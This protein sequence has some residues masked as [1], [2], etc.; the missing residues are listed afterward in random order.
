VS[1]TSRFPLGYND[2]GLKDPG[3]NQLG[4]GGDVNVPNVGEVKESQVVSPSSM[5]MLADSKPDGSF[6]GNVDPRNPQEWPSN[7]HN[8]KT[9]MMFADGHA[10]NPLRKDVIDPKN[11]YWRA[12]WNNDNQP[13][14]EISWTVNP[15]QERRIDP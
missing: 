2:W 10:E 6:D 9:T 8:R 4:L 7:R 1:S 15:T 14:T 12:R 13:H 3:P 11:N 5:I